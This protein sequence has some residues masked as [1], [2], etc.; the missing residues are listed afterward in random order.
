MQPYALC[1]ELLVTALSHA[2]RQ[3]IVRGHCSH[4][5]V[6]CPPLP[7][8]SPSVMSRRPV[9]RMRLRLRVA[10]WAGGERRRGEGARI[11]RVKLPFA[12]PFHLVSLLRLFERLE[13]EGG[14]QTDNVLVGD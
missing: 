3:S 4:G 8:T 13:K 1:N 6:Q 2:E 12:P 11:S 9:C 10:N 5:A 7:T 14:E